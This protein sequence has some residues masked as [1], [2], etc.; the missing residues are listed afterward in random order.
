MS[1]KL[2]MAKAAIW[3]GRQR[4]ATARVSEKVEQSHIVQLLRSFGC[5][6]YVMGTHRRRGDYQGTMQTAGLPDL[7]AFLPARIGG[8]ATVAPRMVFVECKADGGSLRPE[9]VAF[10]QQAID[11]GIPHVVGGL[12]EVIAWFVDQGYARATQF[13]HYRQPD[14]GPS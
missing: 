3:P 14:R 2:P 4:R 7:L 8:V 12:D 11:A 13:S 6:A 10:R 5:T 1:D 9:Q